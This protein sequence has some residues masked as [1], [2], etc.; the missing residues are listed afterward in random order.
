MPRIYGSELFAN[1]RSGNFFDSLS[2]EEISQQ[3]SIR[4]FGN[5]NVGHLGF[6]NLQVA[7][8]LTFGAAFIV[9][10]WYART[11]IPWRVGSGDT[12]ELLT[13]WS[14][15]SM[16]TLNVGDRQVWMSSLY[17]LLRMWR[18]SDREGTSVE[19]LTTM[20]PRVLWP[21]VIPHRQSVNVRFDSFG[22]GIDGLRTSEIPS[23]PRIWVHLEGLIVPAGEG[24]EVPRPNSKVYD[25]IEAI[26]VGNHHR[27]SAEDRIVEW[28]MGVAEKTEGDASQL[29][30]LADG[31]LEG[32][33]R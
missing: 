20:C 3:R 32:R 31:I 22:D 24:H 33:H 19:N 14:N 10:H 9:T 21:E 1:L 13:A 23:Y 11:D 16:L 4:M 25:I 7:G 29:H 15:A 28:I 2:L 30:A 12:A 5:Q 8:Q 6:T 26:T 27:K 17:D 18:W